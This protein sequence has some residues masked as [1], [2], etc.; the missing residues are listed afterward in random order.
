[1]AC[2]QGFLG[3]ICFFKVVDGSIKLGDKIKFMATGREFDVVELG[4]LNPKRNQVE[5]LKTGEVGYFAGSIKEITR[6]VG[7][8]ITHVEKPA[9]EPLEGYKEA[10]PMVFSGLYPV[11]N[12]QYH[13][14][15][16]VDYHQS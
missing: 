1:M 6:F 3:T 2:K 11:D 15:K 8:T 10:K 7:D 14:L 4:F 5:E 13:D 16:W 9:S 12:D